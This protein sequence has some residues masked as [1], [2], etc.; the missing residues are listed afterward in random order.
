[1]KIAVFSM[2]PLF[3]HHVHG[4]SQKLLQ[5]V[6]AYL[7]SQG[8]Q[9]D[10]YCTRRDDNFTSFHLAPNVLVQPI[11]RFKQTYPDPYWT[12]PYHLKDVILTLA[13]AIKSHDVFYIHD[14]ELAF[15]FLYEN[16]P[17]V[18]SFQDFVYPDTLANAFSFKRD[19]L[20]LGSSYMKQCVEAIF[21]SFR[22]MDR[23]KIVL[24]PN[25][26]NIRI[27]QKVDGT[28]LR[29]ELGLADDISPILYPHRPDPRKGIYESVLTVSKLKNY[30]PQEVFKKV[31]LL[32]PIWVDSNVIKEES[33]IFMDVYDDIRSYAESLG[34]SHLLYF[35]PWIATERMPEYYSLGK[36]TLCI[37]NF[38]ES[39]GQVSVESELCGTP[40]VISRVGAQRSIL[41]EDIAYKTDYGDAD[42]AAAFL[43]RLLLEDRRSFAKHTNVIRDYVN[44]HYNEE[45]M[46]LGYAGQILNVQ[47]S[48]PMEDHYALECNDDTIGIPPWC[49]ITSH[50]Y[51]VDYLYDYY[52]DQQ[53][54]EIIVS[55]QQP[56][57]I[58]KLKTNG[59]EEEKLAEWVKDGVL[60][61]IPAT[62]SAFSSPFSVI[63]R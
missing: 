22:K 51:Y 59:L 53:L 54:L 40:S 49:A 43:A 61:R 12:A 38:I 63:E 2:G 5:T 16:M 20:I 10:V 8:H 14:S 21:A 42:A 41:P 36:A 29:N 44:T 9:V 28:K 30:V 58:G 60:L 6:L 26:F 7:G 62:S 3:P 24:I 46:L 45:K 11:L 37:G 17:T 34:V 56:V 35:H 32:I 4:G 55:I 19:R 18:V 31:R 33:H 1:M 23:E 52:K 13:R 47:L 57:C 15:H 25:G 50:G 39:F 27:F 48:Q